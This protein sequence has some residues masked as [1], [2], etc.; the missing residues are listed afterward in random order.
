MPQQES[1]HHQG[2]RQACYLHELANGALLLR[3]K[4]VCGAEVAE[5]KQ[6]YPQGHHL[7]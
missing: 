7:V 5:K 3:E 1:L 2:K 6:I 4:S